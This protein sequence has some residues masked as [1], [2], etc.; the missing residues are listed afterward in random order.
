MLELAVVGGLPRV[1]P[2]A[3]RPKSSV[4]LFSEVRQ[5]SCVI[6]TDVMHDS[7]KVSEVGDTPHV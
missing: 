5:P 1:L 2:K 7:A 3:Y 6:D 4:T